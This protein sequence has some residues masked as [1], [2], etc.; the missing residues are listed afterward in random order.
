MMSRA[1]VIRVNCPAFTIVALTALSVIGDV[2]AEPSTSAICSTLHWVRYNYSNRALPLNRVS[3]PSTHA[4]N[5]LASSQRTCNL[6]VI[7]TVSIPQSANLTQFTGF[8]RCGATMYMVA[9]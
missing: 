1:N 3:S 8:R 5:P 2:K 7:P 4:T 6:R 9:C